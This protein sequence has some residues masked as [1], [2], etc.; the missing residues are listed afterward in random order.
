MPKDE[1][2]HEKL[3]EIARNA[4][5]YAQTVK[6]PLEQK[7]REEQVKKFNEVIETERDLLKIFSKDRLKI[8]LVYNK[9]L[10]KF[11]IKPLK[12]TKDIEAVGLDLTVYMDLNDLEKEII[13]KK[14]R[15]EVL[16]GDEQEIYDAKEK[17]FAS[18]HLGGALDQA[19]HLLATFLTPPS[20]SRLKNPEKQYIAKLTFWESFPFDLKM[21]LFSE[22]IDRLGI[23]PETDVKLFQVN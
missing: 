10:L 11:Q 20:F 16:T 14:N 7:E 6:E 5:K 3:E 12:S 22:V 13:L 2:D 9:K 8:E 21:F 23:N 18:S 1:F 15:G 17:E 4:N 19:H